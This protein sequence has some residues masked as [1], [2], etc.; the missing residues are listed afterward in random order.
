MSLTNPGLVAGGIRRVEAA[1]T[2]RSG[3][4]GR[5]MRNRVRGPGLEVVGCNPRLEQDQVQNVMGHARR[6][7]AAKIVVVSSDKLV[8]YGLRYLLTHRTDVRL[9][10]EVNQLK[11]AARLLVHSAPDV[12][13]V[14]GATLDQQSL[15]AAVMR[16]IHYRRPS[17]QVVAFTQ[18]AQVPRL[19][20]SKV[21]FALVLDRDAL[22]PELAETVNAVRANNVDHPIVDPLGP[23]RLG[24]SD[25]SGGHDRLVVP[26]LTE[27]EAEVLELLVYGITNNE[28]A[29]RLHFS[30]STAKY[31]VRNLICKFGVTGRTAVAYEAKR[32]GL[33]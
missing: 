31:H 22:G 21:G 2:D 8:R 5:D 18:T 25:A 17:C 3:A 14:D 33:L 9:Q 16:E 12:I 26:N 23:T 15:D 13:I 27:R 29:K 19:Q 24:A 4:N 32:I 1:R 30:Q 11:D 10:A 6:G 20:M 28:I 7:C